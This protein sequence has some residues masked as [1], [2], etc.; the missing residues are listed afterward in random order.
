MSD[1]IYE[2]LAEALDRLPNGFPRTPSGVEIPMLKK[3]FTDQEA[4]IAGQMGRDL[5][6]AEEIAGRTGIALEGI[7][8]QLKGMVKRGLV[9]VR[10]HNS[11]VC[12]RLAPFI[13]GIYEEHVYEM[14]HEFAHLFEEYMVDGG[15]K[16]IMQPVPALQ[17]VV[18]ARGSIKTEYILPYDDVKAML[19]NAVSFRV[20]DC[21][22]RK[23]KELHGD[24]TCDFPLTMC[25]NFTTFPRAEC[26]ETITREQALAILDKAEEVGL[27]HTVSNVMNGMYYVC[28]C[29]GCCCGIL[30]GITEWGI[31]EA[32]AFANYYASIDKDMCTD[33]GMCIDRCQVHA[34][35]D[36][37][38]KTT[39][40]HDQCIGCGL[41]VTGCPQDAV[42]LTKREG[43][44]INHPPED[45]EAW[46]RLRLEHRGITP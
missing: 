3:I 2:H 39:I 20:R 28:N 25:L 27:V 29:C 12:Y 11:A 42:T 33:C 21:I 36:V 7:K 34:I 40:I 6:T 30:R 16:G 17:R 8:I 1:D 13:V 24:R 26:D 19:D 22:C 43:A 32:V 35:M 9:W 14:D 10:K 31:K 15:A 41:C 37:H 44:A 45:F 4:L 18:P 46:E 23:Q 38:G 5:E